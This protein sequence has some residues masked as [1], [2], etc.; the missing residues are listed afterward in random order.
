MKHFR[1]SKIYLLRL[2]IVSCVFSAP[3]ISSS[4]AIAWKL[5]YLTWHDMPVDMTFDISSWEMGVCIIP[6]PFVVAN[7][8]R[9]IVLIGFAK[10]FEI[11]LILRPIFIFSVTTSK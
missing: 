8:R 7:E 11:V 3:A 1:S 4:A 5:K 9:K 10:M 2:S 6:K